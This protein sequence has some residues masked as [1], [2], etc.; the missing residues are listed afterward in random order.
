MKKLLH[1]GVASAAVLASVSGARAGAFALHEQSTVGLSLAY[2]GVAAGS[3]GLSSMFWNPATL[4]DNPGIQTQSNYSGIIPYA[5]TTPLSPG[6]SATLLGLGGTRD[7]GNILQS[8]VVP[9]SYASYQ[10]NDQIFLGLGVNAPFGLASK[11]PTNW[12]GQIY[13]QTSRVF[14]TDVQPT[15]AYKINDIISIG[16]G[17]QVEYFKTR[18]TSAVSP[19]PTA[20]SFDLNGDSIGV[21]FTVGATIKPFVGTEV[22]IGYRSQVKE[23][24]TGTLT[25]FPLLPGTVKIKSNITLPDQINIGLRQQVTD[26][27]IANFGAEWS[28]WSV[29]N[30]FPVVI[31]S[32]PLAGISPLALG[33]KYKDGYM[34][35]VGGEYL[36]DAFWTFR[37]GF[38]YEKSPITDSVRATR[39]PDNDRYW[40]TIGASYKWSDKLTLNASYAHV[41]SASTKI[42][43]V[44]GNPAF[45]PTAPFTF[46][47]NVD[48]RTDII[49]AGMT[50][51]WDDP[52]VVASNL[53]LVRK[54]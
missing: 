29:F 12:S 35:S 11:N 13:G 2:A 40:A 52:K 42:N 30:Q 45:I 16:V 21:G 6:T 48:A 19:L 18:L 22:G 24:L 20:T 25:G 38:A 14:T 46:A 39:L 9:A 17:L 7:S 36:W 31:T 10:F 4:T 51:R 37:A 3:G 8:A 15:I 41:F 32:A 43:I 34:L 28:H 26:R 47:G 50:Y 53:P 49:S 33:F 5:K 54:P 27:F 44:P 1:I 23:D